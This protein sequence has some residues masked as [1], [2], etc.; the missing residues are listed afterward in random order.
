[1][2]ATRSN[3]N[4][5]SLPVRCHCPISCLL[6]SLLALM[7][8][9][10]HLQC[11]LMGLR[12]LAGVVL[13]KVQQ[14]PVPASEMRMVPLLAGEEHTGCSGT[15]LQGSVPCSLLSHTL[16]R[17]WYS[18]N[19]RGRLGKEPSL[20][21][22]VSSAALSWARMVPVL[23]PILGGPLESSPVSCRAPDGVH[24]QQP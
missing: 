10:H 9:S 19:V 8:S 5:Q 14:Q 11:F 20:L 4:A 15:L 24:C 16:S 23:I 18:A 3:Q 1:M 22:G 21:P 12:V 17:G 13:S 7:S 2:A 6:L